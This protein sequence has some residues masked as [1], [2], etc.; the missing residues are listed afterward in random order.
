MQSATGT[1]LP[2]AFLRPRSDSGP[3]TNR[4]PQ[5]I[6]PQ[7]RME[8]R[9]DDEVLLSHNSLAS[10]RVCGVRPKHQHAPLSGAVDSLINR[11]LRYLHFSKSQSGEGPSSKPGRRSEL[12]HGFSGPAN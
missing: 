1:S 7:A 9:T 12:P 8:F 10:K 5:V 6:S 4:A 11:E 3:S 2:V